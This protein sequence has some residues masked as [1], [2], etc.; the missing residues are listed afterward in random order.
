[1]SG[2]MA[3]LGQRRL[4]IA[5]VGVGNHGVARFDSAARFALRAGA[6]TSS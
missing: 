5:G 4:V 2:G 1:V 6:L 3:Q